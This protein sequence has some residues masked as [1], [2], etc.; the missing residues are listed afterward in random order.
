M[1]SFCERV[2]EIVTKI[3]RGSVASYGQIAFMTGAPHCARHVGW[4]MRRAPEELPC[5]RVIM[6][7][8]SFARGVDG[9]RFRSLLSAEGVT[10]L[11]DGRVDMRKNRWRGR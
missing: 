10:F 7:D 2:Y 11:P 9:E 1:T 6:A 4:A 8:G 3:P 5:H